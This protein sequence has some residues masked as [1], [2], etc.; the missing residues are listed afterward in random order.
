MTL[1][2]LKVQHL[3]HL[4][5][6]ECSRV[7]GIPNLQDERIMILSFLILKPNSVSEAQNSHNDC[8]FMFLACSCC[9]LSL[10]NFEKLSLFQCSFS[11]CAHCEISKCWKCKTFSCK[12]KKMCSSLHLRSQKS[13]KSMF[14]SFCIPEKSAFCEFHGQSSRTTKHV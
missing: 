4:V 10:W 12:D 8:V 6:C 14:V 7:F 3:F 11:Q 5:S 13:Q 1:I 9:V 2:Q